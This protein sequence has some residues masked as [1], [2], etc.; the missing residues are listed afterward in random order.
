M[1][2]TMLGASAAAALPDFRSYAAAIGNN[3]G[4]MNATALAGGVRVKIGDAYLNATANDVLNQAKYALTAAAAGVPGDA[5]AFAGPC[6]R[7]VASRKPARQATLRTIATQTLARSAADR[8]AI[9]GKYAATDAAT[10]MATDSKVMA[11]RAGVAPRPAGFN[12]AS[13]KPDPNDDDFQFAPDG[14]LSDAEIKKKQEE[15]KAKPDEDAGATYTKLELR[16]YE[17]N[18][19]TGTGDSGDT[20]EV[21]MGGVAVGATGNMAKIK[22]F[23]VADDFD[24][25]SDDRQHKK[26]YN[27][28]GWHLAWYHVRQA[29]PFPH[30][31]TAQLSMAELDNGGF[32]DFL[33]EL[34]NKVKDVVKGLI[35][36][37]LESVLG[38]I[39]YVVGEIIGA[40]IDWFIGLFHN[41]DDILG[42]KHIHLRFNSHKLWG[43]QGLGLLDT[44]GRKKTLHYTGYNAVVGWKIMTDTGYNIRKDSIKAHKHQYNQAEEDAE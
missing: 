6:R 15:E 42:V 4:L 41:E 34:W 3:P 43:Y 16:L 36:D 26:Y 38:P 19:T 31:Y 2:Q 12:I 1:L 7:F 44:Y 25:D 39:G 8:M 9:F 17:V 27:V 32:G 21:A 33:I 30:Y 37:A 23:L 5:N 14:F 28:Q 20:E 11:L 24:T 22:R 35:D 13:V 18:I 10:F 40:I 29:G